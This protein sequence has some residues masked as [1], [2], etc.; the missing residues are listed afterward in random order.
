MIDE[1]QSGVI[2]SPNFPNL[3]PHN[4]DC[5]WTVEAPRGNTINITFSHFDVEDP[6][7]TNGSCRYD[8]VQILE[9]NSSQVSVDLRLPHQPLLLLFCS[10]HFARLVRFF[11]DLLRKTVERCSA[12]RI[13]VTRW[14]LSLRLRDVPYISIVIYA[15]GIV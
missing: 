14:L 3:Y 7:S 5:L 12:T 6:T 8:F 2:E 13:P 1:G 4:R 10:M 15:L 11:A 9:S